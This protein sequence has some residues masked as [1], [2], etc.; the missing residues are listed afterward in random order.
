M[1]FNDI[2]SLAKTENVIIAGGTS[3]YK[4]FLPF[5]DTVIRTI[6]AQDYKGNVLTPDFH[7]TDEMSF[8]RIP[9]HHEDEPAY[10]VEYIT[11][12][13]SD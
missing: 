2:L 10:I 3:T 7:I 12:K 13:E 9:V 1:D 8:E 11:L 5:V 6:I 4:D